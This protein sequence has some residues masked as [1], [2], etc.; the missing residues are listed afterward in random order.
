[1]IRGIRAIRSRALCFGVHRSHALCFRVHRSRALCFGVHRS[2]ALRFRVHR[3]R[4]GDGVDAP[5]AGIF[6]MP[7]SA[8]S[9]PACARRGGRYLPSSGEATLWVGRYPS[10][11]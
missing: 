4:G 6:R 10:I 2:R 9:D 3:S 8:A 5:C 11:G 7:L 1:M